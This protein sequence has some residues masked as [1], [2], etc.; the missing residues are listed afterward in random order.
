MRKVI[1]AIGEVLTT[2][3]L[4]VALALLA[5][6]LIGPRYGWSLHT[7]LSGS[8]EPTLGVGGL[9]VTRAVPLEQVQVGH[10]V[11][12]GMG[13]HLVTHRVVEIV[14]REGDPRPWFRTQGDANT[15]PDPQLVS[16]DATWMPKTVAYIPY[17]GYAAKVAGDR[18]AFFLLLGVP[19]LGL[20]AL[21]MREL[22]HGIAE[23]RGKRKARLTD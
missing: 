6:V 17:V 10:I 9:I 2:L 20:V 23:E 21:L 19:G 5:F 8:M 15:S 18:R 11:T 16:S 22:V 14:H 13:D 12:F 4:V 1:K 7:V 3:M